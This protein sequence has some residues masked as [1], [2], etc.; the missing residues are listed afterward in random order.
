MLSRI[1]QAHRPALRVG[2]LGAVEPA[3]VLDLV[4][5]EDQLAWSTRVARKPSISDCGNGQGCDAR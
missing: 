1:G 5:V 4:R 3:R 2:E